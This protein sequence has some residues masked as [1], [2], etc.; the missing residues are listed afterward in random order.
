MNYLN[1]F[2]LGEPMVS[3]PVKTERQREIY[4]TIS[5]G[6][7]EGD[8]FVAKMTDPIIPLKREDTQ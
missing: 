8:T 5:S 4:A 1:V 6:A 7:R 2:V 3:I